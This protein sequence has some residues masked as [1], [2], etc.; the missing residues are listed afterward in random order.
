ME[1]RPKKTAKD[2]P[3]R[4][5][6]RTKKLASGKLWVGYYYNGRDA[7]GKRKEIPLGTDLAA[8]K[9]K[10]AELEGAPSEKNSNLM[11]YIFDRYERE[12]IPKKAFLT[13]RGN[14]SCLNRLK[15]TFS[16]AN[17]DHITPQHIAIYRD[18]RSS[19][20]NANREIALLSHVFNMAREWGYTAK[21]NPVRGVRKNKESPRDYYV[22]SDVWNAVYTE[23]PEELQDAMDI[24]Y[25][26]GQRP[27][28]VL[29]ISLTDIRNGELE[30][31]QK[32]TGKKLRIVL[33]GSELGNVI[34]RIKNR[35]RK[36]MQVRLVATP[37]GQHMTMPMLHRR[38]KAAKD[39]AMVACPD[40][41]DRIQKFQFRDIRPMA[42]TDIPDLEKASKL[43]G[44]T[45]QDITKRVYRR[46]GEKVSPTR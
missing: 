33:G 45:K 32:K 26:T 20:S 23:A 5:L 29:K 35:T 15:K 2:L 37:S 1:M 41:A 6:R 16:G 22:E 21:E 34:N 40:I 12:I 39:A 46:L 30:I 24:A 25:L 19:K 7:D 11:Q 4:M 38:F 31:S 43:L 36:V 8:A 28:D 13:Q 18:A 44:H 17:I 27:S 9:R 42:A 10:W 3:P 14:R